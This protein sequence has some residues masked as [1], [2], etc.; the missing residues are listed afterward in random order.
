MIELYEGNLKGVFVRTRIIILCEDSKT[1]Y[2]LNQGGRRRNI[3]CMCRNC[4][5]GEWQHLERLMERALEEHGIQDALVRNPDYGVLGTICKFR[6]AEV[7]E[8]LGVIAEGICIDER[9]RW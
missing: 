9:G 2:G 4:D 7:A 5:H 6:M 3:Y 1:R 8:C